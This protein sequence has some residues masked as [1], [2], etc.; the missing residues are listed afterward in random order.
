MAVSLWAF[1]T[2]FSNPTIRVVFHISMFFGVAATYAIVA[3][4]L[5]FRA[6]ERVEEQVT[7]IDVDIKPEDET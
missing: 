7:N 2:F 5:G 6:T 4:G 3:T 1:Y